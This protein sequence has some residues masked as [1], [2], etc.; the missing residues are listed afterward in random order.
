MSDLFNDDEFHV[1]DYFSESEKNFFDSASS[2][3]DE[4]SDF[5]KSQIRENEYVL[6]NS[7]GLTEDNAVSLDNDKNFATAK[8]EKMN[9]NY[10]EI[11]HQ[12]SKEIVGESDMWEGG[13]KTYYTAEATIGIL[14][15]FATKAHADDFMTKLQ[16]SDL[17]GVN[18]I[19]AEQNLGS[20]NYTDE[21]IAKQ[22]FS[23]AFNINNSM[24]LSRNDN[25]FITERNIYTSI[26]DIINTS[27]SDFLNACLNNDTF[28]YDKL[29]DA[30]FTIDSFSSESIFIDATGQSLQEF[31]Q[32]FV[33]QNGISKDSNQLF[34]HELSSQEMSFSRMETIKDNYLQDGLYEN[35]KVKETLHIGNI[36]KVSSE[37]IDYQGIL[38]PNS[39][40]GIPL[41]KDGKI[42][43]VQPLDFITCVSGKD[44]RYKTIED[45]RNLKVSSRIT[46]RQLI[47]YNIRPATYM[48]QC[49]EMIEMCSE[50]LEIF[51]L[52]NAGKMS[53]SSIDSLLKK[54]EYNGFKLNDDSRKI[55][56]ALKDAKLGKNKLNDAKRS[57]KRTQKSWKKG[58][59]KIFCNNDLYRGIALSVRSS[60]MAWFLTKKAYSLSLKSLKVARHAARGVGKA[61]NA[62]ANF[63]GLSNLTG[64]Q[65][66][67]N[68]VTKIDNTV[69]KVLDAGEIKNINKKIE[70]RKDI[71][72]TNKASRRTARKTK[73]KNKNDKIK[74]KLVGKLNKSKFGRSLVR[75][76]S[77]FKAVGT[78]VANTAKT[79]SNFVTSPLKKIFS[80][81]STIKKWIAIGIVIPCA[82]V[83]VIIFVVAGSSS[84]LM[85]AISS[86]T[87]FAED[88]DEDINAKLG[89]K[90]VDKLREKSSTL[91]ADAESS[92]TT[93]FT[94]KSSKYHD[95][96]GNY[97]TV[98]TI[99]NTQE[100]YK[101]SDGE[102][103]SLTDFMG[104]KEIMA[105]A[106]VHFQM[107]YT[108]TSYKKFCYEM[109]DNS[110]NYSVSYSD[111]K[112]CSSSDG[113]DNWGTYYHTTDEINEGLC[114]CH[115]VA[116]KITENYTKVYFSYDD[117]FGVIY[118]CTLKVKGVEVTGTEK[119]Q[120]FIINDA[121]KEI[122]YDSL[123]PDLYPD[124]KGDSSTS[125]VWHTDSSYKTKV[126]ATIKSGKTTSTREVGYYIPGT[127]TFDD[128]DFVPVCNGHE[129]C[130]GHVDA[131]VTLTANTLTTTTSLYNRAD[132]LT[133]HM[134]YI[135][136]WTSGL[137]DGIDFSKD[138]SFREWV[139]L[140][141]EPNW[142]ELYGIYLGA[143]EGSF[144]ATGETEKDIWN[145][146]KSCGLSDAGAAGVMGNL[147][148]ESGFNPEAVNDY[149]YTGIAQ[150]GGSRLDKL[151]SQAI[152]EGRS[153]TDLDF[154]LDFLMNEL[155]SSYSSVYSFMLS[156]TDPIEAACY[157]AAYY[158]GCYIAEGKPHYGDS[159]YYYFRSPSYQYWQGLPDRK[160]R[161]QAFYSTYAGT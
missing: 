77:K 89:N 71:A 98:S 109:F 96:S 24:I 110:H 12:T 146:L 114:S 76:T 81:F 67:F 95:A 28:K 158:E 132:E 48:R 20:F 32:S 56:E 78:K 111:V 64:Y 101:N 60:K 4:Y 58:F 123:N 116:D 160:S 39:T 23:E 148:V 2:K 94:G 150:W 79:V 18:K 145:Y 156:A 155:Q 70:K 73:R 134:E 83:L 143:S 122:V 82:V 103:I 115:T 7:Y 16:D 87:S 86:I 63:T 34:L 100:Y 66:I 42:E 90:V 1:K 126:Y 55:L 14:S 104:I 62:V 75:G 22:A 38:N 139:D 61:G 136:G 5:R 26:T 93:N 43:Y 108:K 65:K 88:D 107:D 120:W 133:S 21:K 91:I 105:I 119:G 10:Q 15:S 157:F 140:L 151:K 17:S 29:K 27:N 138:E 124:Y 11:V 92:V 80:F 33:Q 99:R 147:S 52:K 129:A 46:G 159:D 68:G 141:L 125:W 142:G 74:K 84:A 41:Y 35:S 54:G 131:T 102:T 161:A 51:G 152:A 130:L 121:T 127:K 8:K 137:D 40:V 153:Y 135:G 50:S 128:P 44:Q 97:Y 144:E 9:L 3:I 154:Q 113:C 72:Q 117:T 49:Q 149:G 30:A 106:E 85:S 57:S 45:K 47:S 69:G 25:G 53:V 36:P 37:N 118:P 19:F 6:N 59:R 13:R 31:A 112:Y